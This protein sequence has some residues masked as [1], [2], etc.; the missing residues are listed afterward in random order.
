MACHNSRKCITSKTH[1][2]SARNTRLTAEWLK[3][4]I[5]EIKKDDFSELVVEPDF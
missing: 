5:T 1:Q 3:T 4:T 2:C